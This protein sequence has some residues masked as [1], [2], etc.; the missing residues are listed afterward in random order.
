[1][2]RDLPHS[3]A[4]VGESS[5]SFCGVAT[6]RYQVITSIE[7]ASE[8]IRLKRQRDSDVKERVSTKTAESLQRAVSRQ[9]TSVNLISSSVPK[10]VPPSKSSKNVRDIAP[11]QHIGGNL[12]QSEKGTKKLPSSKVTTDVYLPPQATST[13]SRCSKLSDDFHPNWMVISEVPDSVCGADISEFL[14]GLKIKEIFGYYH[15]DASSSGSQVP[16]NMMDIYVQFE[17]K[18]GVDAAMLRNGENITAEAPMD[19]QRTCTIGSSRR[20][21]SFAACLDRVS[22]AEASWAKALS[23]NLEYSVS[24][25]MTVLE[26]FRS[27]FPPSLMSLTPLDSLK[28][29]S[30]IMPK[31]KFLTPDEIYNHTDHNKKS[32]QS[33]RVFRYD[34]H[35]TDGLYI[36]TLNIV[37]GVGLT[38]L[39]EL[40][41]YDSEGDE[42]SKFPR[43][44]DECSLTQGPSNT[45][46]YM[47]AK[48]ILEK[49][50]TVLSTALLSSYTTSPV[51]KSDGFSGVNSV[52]DLANRMSNMYQNIL[53][54]LKI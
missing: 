44:Q 20:R 32:S 7:N 41:R 19:S 17:S 29:W 38:G 48:G 39:S 40:S 46:H 43:Y 35:T 26:S 12:K 11:I 8:V 16:S 5:L 52:L 47:V 34:Y 18:S 31:Y 50:S 4:A 9:N 13:R 49:L 6:N 51:A 30:A 2:Y 25:C 37:G 42:D 54:E 28:K 23:V 53:S 1:M 22:R 24:H 14:N 21:V 33:S 27:S 3:D 10:S 45:T 15:Y 36:D